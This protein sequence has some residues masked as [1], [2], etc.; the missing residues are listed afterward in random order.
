MIIRAMAD[1]IHQQRA[2]A[3][4][5]AKRWKIVAIVMG[6]LAAILA[7]ALVVALMTG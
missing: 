1:V 7:V 3:Q 5:T 2:A 6:V 4:E